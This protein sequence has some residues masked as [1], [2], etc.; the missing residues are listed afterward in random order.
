MHRGLVRSGR[1]FAAALFGGE[2]ITP[3]DLDRLYPAPVPPD[4]MGWMEKIVLNVL[5]LVGLVLIAV[6]GFAVYG[7]WHFAKGLL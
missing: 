5:G 1:D 6:V 7:A 2:M 3:T 4:R